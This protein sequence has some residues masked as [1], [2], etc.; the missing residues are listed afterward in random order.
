MFFFSL[1]QKFKNTIFF[2]LLT[3]ILFN[4]FSCASAQE[5][6]RVNKFVFDTAP[7]NLEETTE[8]AD[9]IFAGVCTKTEKIKNDIVSG[10]PVIKYTFKVT[11]GIK[12][13]EDKSEIS[14]KQWEA[15]SN[16]NSHYTEG[17]KYL[18]FL[19]P[20]SRKGLTSPVGFAQGQFEVKKDPYS[21][22]ESVKNRLGNLGLITN[23]V[24]KKR[25]FISGDAELS[26]YLNKSSE[27]GDFIRYADLIKA[28]KHLVKEK[29]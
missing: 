16:D 14:F 8:I 12:G 23:I 5:I 13:A 9:R 29:Q 7:L 2:V 3:N 28:V 19:Y 26:N 21:K 15:L 22:I 1:N 18:L 24:T 10:L 27:N 4:F 20:D 6:Q 25:V 17:E 11:D